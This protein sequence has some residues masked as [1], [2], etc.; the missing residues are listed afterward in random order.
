MP[1]HLS[2]HLLR[3][4]THAAARAT[5]RPAVRKESPAL[6]F[7]TLFM[8]LRALGSRAR[9]LGQLEFGIAEFTS[10]QRPALTI[11]WLI[12]WSIICYR[13]Y[14]VVVGPLV[15]VLDGHFVPGYAGKYRPEISETEGEFEGVLPDPVLETQPQSAKGEEEETRDILEALRHGQEALNKILGVLDKFDEFRDRTATFQDPQWSCLLFVGL[16]ILLVSTTILASKV[17]VPLLFASSAWLAVGSSHPQVNRIK[18]DLKEIELEIFGESH[19]L[20]HLLLWAQEFKRSF[21]TDDPPLQR[22]VEIFELQ[23][24]GLTPRLWDTVLYSPFVYTPQSRHRLA[25][26]LPPGSRELDGVLPPEGWY[27]SE[28]ENWKPDSDVD[29][30]TDRYVPDV[31]IEN[32]WACD[33]EWRR[34]RLTRVCYHHA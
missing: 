25:Q 31:S 7:Y 28:S 19:T 15:Y 14:L 20:E 27:F 6:S 12:L 29:W 33:S 30:V 10:W 11:S 34:R 21:I 32:E 17:S 8:S 26:Q 3:I 18:K 24:Q 2:D 22:E 4:A 13:P 9:R 1:E 23:R 5:S 16:L